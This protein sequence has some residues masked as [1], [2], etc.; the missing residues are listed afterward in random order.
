MSLGELAWTQRLP[1]GPEGVHHSQCCRTRLSVATQNTCHGWN[2][3]VYD[4]VLNF[5]HLRKSGM[6][7][8]HDRAGYLDNEAALVLPIW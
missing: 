4:T 6:I 5:C 2:R 3:S 7:G 8:A 1:D